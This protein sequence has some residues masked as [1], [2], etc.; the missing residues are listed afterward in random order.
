MMPMSSRGWWNSKQYDDHSDGDFR[1][2]VSK[3][4]LLPWHWKGLRGEMVTAACVSAFVL[5]VYVHAWKAGIVVPVLILCLAKALH[6]WHPYWIEILVR[7][8]VQPE[9]FQDS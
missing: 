4:N 7:L 5:I 3:A 1:I 6:N 9:G 8:L 2:P